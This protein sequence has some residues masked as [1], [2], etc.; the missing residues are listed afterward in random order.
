LGV[1]IAS[2]TADVGIVAAAS[3][4]VIA[5]LTKASTVAGVV[6][7][8]VF[9]AGVVDIIIAAVVVVALTVADV[10]ADIISGG[11]LFADVVAIVVAA[12]LSAELGCTLLPPTHSAHVQSEVDSL[13]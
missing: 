9:V 10:V 8:A 4:P 2:V 1:T 11:I 7:G 3:V 5:L 12:V 6:S 13:R